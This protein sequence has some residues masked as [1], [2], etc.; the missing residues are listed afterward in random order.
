MATLP[1]WRCGIAFGLQT[2][3]GTPATAPSLILPLVE[4]YRP[5]QWG[6]N[7]IDIPYASNNHWHRVHWR[8]GDEAPQ[9]ESTFTWPPGL[10]LQ[11]GEEGDTDATDLAK[12]MFWRQSVTAAELVDYPNGGPLCS[13]DGFY[14]TFWFR[15]GANRTERLYD[16]KCLEGSLQVGW[17]DLATWRVKCAAAQQPGTSAEVWPVDSEDSLNRVP[18]KFNEVVIRCGPAASLEALRL[19]PATI[20]TNQPV[21][22]FNQNVADPLSMCSLARK[23]GTPSRVPRKLPN[24]TLP[25]WQGITELLT[26]AWSSR[27]AYLA[28]TEWAYELRLRRASLGVE[29]SV[30]L[31]RIVF[32][33]D[34]LGA[35]VRSPLRQRLPFEAY[36]HSTVGYTCRVA[37]TLSE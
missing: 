36:Y 24:L 15:M 30:H 8:P 11:W 12:W 20:H 18:Y 29:A 27:I 28:R 6:P 4:Q 2:V 19:F 16:V 37:E 23:S 17:G 32:T 5:P 3:R 33:E 31:P 26:P 7:I 9:F 34:G 10:L 35:A 14:G 1:Y 22:S 25:S 21:L 13:G